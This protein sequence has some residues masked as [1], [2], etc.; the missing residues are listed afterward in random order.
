MRASYI[1]ALLDK[2]KHD[3]CVTHSKAES[4]LHYSLDHTHAEDLEINSLGRNVRTRLYFTS[5]SHLHTLLNVL[6]YSKNGESVIS[7]EGKQILESVPE[8]SYL[9]QIIIRLFETENG[10]GEPSFR[11]E[12]SFSPGAVNDP[13]VDKSSELSPYVTISSAVTFE[14]MISILD[15]GIE[16]SHSGNRSNLKKAAGEVVLADQSV[17]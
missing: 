3:L 7:E 10:T 13:L 9:T 12:I 11:C 1:G 8:L 16:I 5:E 4:D 14:L 15:A 6:R 17:F 2:I